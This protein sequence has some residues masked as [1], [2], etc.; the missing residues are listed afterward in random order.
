MFASRISSLSFFNKS[1]GLSRTLCKTF[2]VAPGIP[3]KP[4]RYQYST[5]PEDKSLLNAVT[6]DK[7]LSV[8]WQDGTARFH[9]VWL[10]H[11][12][13]CPACLDP[14]TKQRTIDM[15]LI[16]EQ[17]RPQQVDVA[18]AD[19]LHIVWE[20]GHVTCFDASWLKENAYDAFSKGKLK[21]GFG[22]IANESEMIL[23]NKEILAANPSPEFN[24]HDVM[25][26]EKLVQECLD[27]LFRYGFTFVN[28]TPTDEE[29]LAKVCERIAGHLQ[30]T[31]YDGVY[32]IENE[33]FSL[34]DIAY[35]S[36][37]LAGHTGH[38]Y[39]MQPG[40]LQAMHLTHHHGSGGTSLL[41]DG[42]W[43][44]K[45][46]FEEDP[47]AFKILTSTDVPFEF[48]GKGLCTRAQAPLLELHPFTQELT[49]L[50][51]NNARIGALVNMNLTFEEMEKFYQAVRLFGSI[52]RRP[53]N[54]LWF[55]LTPGKVIIMDNRRTLHGRSKVSGSR[56][57]MGCYVGI[58]DYIGKWRANKMNKSMS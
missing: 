10:R 18:S 34:P 13:P 56:K 7:S 42:F 20:D 26:D 44:A 6:D 12:C 58:D 35:F 54:E 19:Q 40:G 9:H 11:H 16:P 22:T 17:V 8:H 39:F 47:D 2:R 25:N 29:S 52:V 31:L 3:C 5:L 27:S 28:E 51:Y 38:T 37:A 43:A 15:A 57:L 30:K 21:R 55:N 36:N 23:W 41:V 49:K 33:V 50:R 46:L 1:V 53:E 32:T 14:S 24:Y 48:N 4:S 45:S